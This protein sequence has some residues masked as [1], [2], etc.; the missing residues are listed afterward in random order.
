MGPETGAPFDPK[1]SCREPESRAAYVGSI[2][3]D[4]TWRS[5]PHP[6]SVRLSLSGCL[7]VWIYASSFICMHWYLN[8]NS[9]PPVIVYMHNFVCDKVPT[10]V[11]SIYLTAG[12]RCTGVC[13]IRRSG[14]SLQLL[15]TLCF[16]PC[17]NLCKPTHWEECATMCVIVH[18]VYPYLPWIY[19]YFMTMLIIHVSSIVSV[20]LVW[21]ITK[22]VEMAVL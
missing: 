5:K 9:P 10:K 1:A 7:Y 17:I 21:S 11:S 2:S 20:S 3:L 13:W 12:P 15:S 22:I 14:F 4:P 16:V 8:R 6:P 19:L 18:P